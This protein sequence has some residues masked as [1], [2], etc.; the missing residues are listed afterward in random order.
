FGD[1]IPAVTCPP[2]ERLESFRLQAEAPRG[3]WDDTAANDLQVTCSGG[4]VLDG[5]GN[6]R[7]SWGE[8]SSSCP[9]SCG[10]CGLQTRVDPSYDAYDDSGLNDVRFYCC[11]S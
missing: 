4:D 3:T 10:V 2:G 1:W 8:W 7:G 6:D 11:S 5:G 9:M